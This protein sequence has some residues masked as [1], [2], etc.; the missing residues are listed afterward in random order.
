[1]ASSA[2]AHTVTTPG[3]LELSTGLFERTAV[4]R[5]GALPESVLDVLSGCGRPLGASSVDFERHFGHDFSRVRVHTDMRAAA[6]ARDVDALAYTVGR[7]VVFGDRRFA[8]DTSSG[9]RLLTHELAHTLQQGEA[10][11]VSAEIVPRDDPFEHEA[12]QVAAAAEIASARPLRRMSDLRVARVPDDPTARARYPTVDERGRAQEILNPQHQ[13]AA[14]AGGAV[15]PVTDPAGFRTDMTTRL[16]AHID[17][18]LPAAQAREASSISL[19]LPQ[20][21]SLSDVAQPAVERFYGTYLRAAVHS[22]AEQATRA[23]Y[24]VRGH[25]HLV[26]ER[27]PQADVI[28][29]HWVASRMQARGSDLIESYH[30]IADENAAK[31]HCNAPAS[32]GPAPATERDQALFESVRDAIVA[33]RLADLRTIVLFQSSFEA[34]GEAFIQSQIA[35]VGGEQAGDTQRR[36]RWDA[37]ATLVHE[38]LHAVAH[39]QFRVAAGQIES[40]TL[41]VEGFA[42]Y[43]TRPVYADLTTRARGDSTLRASVEGVAAPLTAGVIPERESYQ[44]LVDRV[45]Q[46]KD[47]LGSNE[48]NLRVAFFMGRLEYLGLGGWTAEEAARRDA[49]RQPANV[50]GGAALLVDQHG[51]FRIDYGR[52][53]IGRGGDFQLQLGGTVNYLTQGDRLGLGG[54]ATLQYSWPYVYVRGGAAVG[55]STSLMQRFSTSVRMDVIPGVEAGVRI[56]IVRVG[57]GANLLIPVGG[58]ISDRTLKLGG[59]VGISADF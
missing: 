10:E 30:V 19:G 59:L 2:P 51:F 49:L 32:S 44:P 7:H 28:A 46:L 11:G 9:R 47:I 8:P 42:E 52:V 41:A 17:A 56:G 36:G 4:F 38:M 35:P 43:F 23:G 33:A 40:T 39:E 24:R 26:S 34:D 45:T 37:L 27:A 58:P 55:A 18:N 16:N 5:S 12:E 3:P 48:E 53:V 57:A 21:Q 29:C 20:I 15:P 22:Q 6:S 25:T 31:R 50:L 13:A 54:T 1:M 14:A